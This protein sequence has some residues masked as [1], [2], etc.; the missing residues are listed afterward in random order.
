MRLR[1]SIASSALAGVNRVLKPFGYSLKRVRAPESRSEQPRTFYRPV[2]SCQISNLATLYERAF[3]QRTDATFVEV[4]AYDGESF[5]NTSCLAD[6][7][8]SGVLIEPVPQFA[9]LCRER[10][11]HNPAVRVVESAVGRSAGSLQLRVAGQLTTANTHVLA[12]Y[13]HIA[14]SER[15]LSGDEEVIEVSVLDLDSILEA[16]AV[17]PG[18]EVLVV[19]VEGF[20]A[21][22]FA[23]FSLDRWQPR[24]M[25]VELADYHP[26]LRSTCGQDAELLATLENAGYDIV[27]KD[28]VNT[29]LVRDARP[30]LSRDR[31]SH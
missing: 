7:G 28:A 25:I 18:F 26:D 24:M 4:G 3:G 19:D 27:Y 5:S 9:E 17:R 31:L 2:A 22:V 10:H 11:K 23:G 20:E 30:Q 1:S 8:W 12:E 6:I 14:W 21:E 13:R 15:L 29:V 16:E